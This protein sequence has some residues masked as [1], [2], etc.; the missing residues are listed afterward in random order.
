MIYRSKT[1]V[2]R[3]AIMSERVYIIGTTERIA[4]GRIFEASVPPPPPRLPSLGSSRP[5]I[6]IPESYQIL[7]LC[8]RYKA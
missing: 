7:N 6:Q 4:S 1:F 2:G 3:P 8:R 5:K